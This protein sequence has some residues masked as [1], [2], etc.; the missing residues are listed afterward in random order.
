MPKVSVSLEGF[1]CARCGHQW[2]ARGPSR[3]VPKACPSC[4]SLLWDESRP[5]G[6][7][8]YEEF[9]DRVQ[10][11]LRRSREGLTWAELRAAGGFATT[12]PNASWAGRLAVDIGLRRQYEGRRALVWRLAE[13]KGPADLES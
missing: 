7:I 10:A 13:L 1:A 9:R 8:T 5:A 12:R 6:V 2:V 3:P 11:L 4:K